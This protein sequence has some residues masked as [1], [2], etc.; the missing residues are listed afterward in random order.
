MQLTLGWLR[1]G[2]WLVR[3]RNYAGR[4]ATSGEEGPFLVGLASARF[5]LS[6]APSVVTG[7][8]KKCFE[9]RARFYVA[10]GIPRETTQELGGWRSSAVMEGM[11]ARARSEEG[12]PGNARGGRQGL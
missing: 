11:Y 2:S 10:D 12:A 6:L 7:S 9:E 5:G 3:R 1:F 4:L 8:R